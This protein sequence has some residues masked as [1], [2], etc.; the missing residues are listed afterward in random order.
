MVE[1]CCCDGLPCE[2]FIVELGYGACY[3]KS[4]DG[5]L[6]FVCHRFKADN[7]VSFEESIVPKGL[8]PK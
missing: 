3:V 2:R 5:K 1:L 7:F 6:R 4:L 8:I